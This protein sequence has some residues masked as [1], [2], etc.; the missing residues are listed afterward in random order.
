MTATGRNGINA[1]NVESCPQ[2]II[3]ARLHNP[4]CPPIAKEPL[5][6]SAPSLAELASVLIPRASTATRSSICMRAAHNR[7]RPRDPD[8]A[9]Y[10]R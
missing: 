10:G 6:E 1:A 4:L 2:G 7:F 3:N 8:M 9:R 5:L